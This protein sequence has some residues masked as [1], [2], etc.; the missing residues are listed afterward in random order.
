MGK[1]FRRAA[2]DKPLSAICLRR[3]HVPAGEPSNI[4][5]AVRLSSYSNICLQRYAREV[6]I[7]LESVLHVDASDDVSIL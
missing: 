5:A 2:R 3:C 7:C 4:N 1:V 6:A